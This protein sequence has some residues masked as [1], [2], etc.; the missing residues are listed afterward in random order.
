[1]QFMTFDY[2][3]HTLTFLLP[4]CHQMVSPAEA[5]H[6]TAFWDYSSNEIG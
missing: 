2:L 3:G 5:Q 1:M 4:L 6:Y